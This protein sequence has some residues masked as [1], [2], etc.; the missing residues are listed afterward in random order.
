M[1]LYLLEGVRKH[2]WCKVNSQFK[3]VIE[4]MRTEKSGFIFKNL[5]VKCPF[6]TCHSPLYRNHNFYFLFFLITEADFKMRV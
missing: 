5:K 1:V 4:Q 2:L 3:L 6:L